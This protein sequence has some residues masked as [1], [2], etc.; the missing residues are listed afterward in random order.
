MS[1]KNK[2]LVISAVGVF[3]IASVVILINFF[4][5]NKE[6]I[7][8]IPK[9]S[10]AVARLDLKSLSEKAEISKWN[11]LKMFKNIET[12]SI[13]SELKVIGKICQTPE[14]S[15]IDFKKCVYVFFGEANEGYHGVVLGL[16]DSE[17]FAS[18]IKSLDAS[19]VV[20]NN[21]EKTVSYTKCMSSN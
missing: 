15:G 18:I 6:L 5:S 11:E 13:G 1:K 9:D 16:H 21:K 2:I 20:Q 14:T 8:R 10:T 3:I 7:S 12:S 4:F 19:I 17:R